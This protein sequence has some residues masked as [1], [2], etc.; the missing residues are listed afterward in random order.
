[1][2][3]LISILIFIAVIVV[4]AVLFGGWLIIAMIR[5][6]FHALFGLFGV[7]QS[8]ARS[9]AVRALTSVQCPRQGCRT[10]NPTGARFCRRCG[11]ELPSVQ[12]VGVRRAAMW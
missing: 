2:E 6:V 7:D 3:V 11:G 8:K 5:L 1:M 12:R 4:T 9:P 10:S